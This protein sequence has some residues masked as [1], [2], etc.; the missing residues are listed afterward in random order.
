MTHEQQL[1]SVVHC[2]VGPVLGLRTWLLHP[3]GCSAEVLQPDDCSA[4]V[5]HPGGCFT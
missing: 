1:L 3:G 2:T 5:L 4:E